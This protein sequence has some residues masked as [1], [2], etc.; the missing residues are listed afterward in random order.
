MSQPTDMSGAGLRPLLCPRSIAVVG[1]SATTG[2]AGNAMVRS[3]L[4]FPGALHL[5]NPTTREIEGRAVA[6]SVQAIGAP[7]DLAVLVVPAQAVPSALADC[8]AAGVRAAVI[9][10]G[11]FAETAGGRQ[12]QAEVETAAARYGVR[13]LGPNTSGFMNPVDGV[14]ANFVPYVTRLEPGPASIVASSGGMNLALSFL[15][16]GEGLGLRLGVGLG[17]AADVGFAEVLDFLAEDDATKVIGIHIEGVDDGRLLYDAIGRVSSDKPVVAL[18]VGRA[19]VGEFA[20][21]HTGRLLGDFEVSRAALAQA[22]AVVVDD[23]G[24]LVDA[25]RA[26]VMCRMP[27]SPAPGIGVVT[28]QAGP[29]LFITDVL[30]SRGVRVPPLSEPTVKGLERLLPPLTMLTNPVDTGRPSETFGQVLAAV[31]SD[32]SIDALVVYAL[33]ESD[34]IN[35]EVAFRTPGVGGEVPVVFGTSGPRE[36]LELGR[37][38][39]D[40]MGVPQYPTPEQAARVAC[41]LVEDARARARRGAGGVAAAPT[42]PQLPDE[43]LDEDLSKALL[44]A[45]GV[46]TPPR[47]VC[48]DRDSAHEAFRI[49]GAP[50]VVKVLDPAIAHKASAGGVHLGIETD[51]QLDAALD[52]VDAIHSPTSRGYLV[53]RQAEP[54]TELLVGGV[55]DRVWGPVVALGRGGIDAESH[56]ATWRLAPLSDLD[57]AELVEETDPSVDPSVVAP[58]IRAVEAL[59]LGHPTISE[60]DVNPVRLTARGAIAL[61]ALVVCATGQEE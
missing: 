48:V 29:G 18:K 47:R 3:L 30:R 7:V 16:G 5:V 33:K 60:I 59:L 13:V 37:R 46:V 25:M 15:A 56:L 50:V 42:P 10:A 11:G 20:L 19:D 38:T 41:A 8:G 22:G 27:P 24:Q 58:V 49:L 40:A 52:A 34:V 32:D 31:A 35:P 51:V 28:A 4:G 23:V 9:C 12:L 6:P 43:P 26:L 2:K 54:G 45:L 14:L 36:M 61:D 17:N 1:A 39:L 57:I 55:R 53:E 21:S 44:D